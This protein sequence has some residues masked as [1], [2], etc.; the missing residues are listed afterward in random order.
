M[1]RIDWTEVAAGLFVCLIVAV[2]IAGLTIPVWAKRKE[3][4]VRMKEAL[5]Q[6][7]PAHARA[8]EDKE[9]LA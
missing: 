5:Q 9:A 2:V 4:N 7:A 6:Q 3:S 1:K 8:G